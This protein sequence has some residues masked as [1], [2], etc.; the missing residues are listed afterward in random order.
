MSAQR[1]PLTKRAARAVLPVVRRVLALR[2][3]ATFIGPP[4]LALADA[5]PSLSM[6][7]DATKRRASFYQDARHI[8]LQMRCKR[9]R[10]SL[11]RLAPTVAQTDDA[12]E[13]WLTRLGIDAVGDE[14]AMTLEL[15]ALLR[16][17]FAR[18]RFQVG[19]DHAL[20]IRIQRFEEIAAAGVRLRFLEQ[21]VVD[22]H[23]GRAR[24]CRADPVNVALDLVVVR[25]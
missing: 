4:G 21:A 8:Q 16:Q 22:T 19:V 10:S 15:I 12:I 5:A 13:Y 24:G 11:R 23:F 20:R 6:E 17:R 1:A 14:I 9:V 25:A 2:R 18:A 3:A 7:H